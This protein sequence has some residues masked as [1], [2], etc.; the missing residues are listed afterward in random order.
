MKSSPRAFT[1]IELMLVIVIL[2]ISSAALLVNFRSASQK[3]L[4]EDQL[5]N[6][7]NVIEKARS[8]SLTNYLVNDFE[9]AE[10][11]LL[12]IADNSI[13][14]EA[15][16]DYG[17]TH[18]TLEEYDLPIGFETTA[19]DDEIFYFPPYGQ[20]CLTYSCTMAGFTKYSFTVSS[21][22]GSLTQTITITTHGG[23]AEFE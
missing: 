7:V 8:Y 4:F 18:E 1:L 11:Y 14:I 12:T 2:A 3:A 5:S 13:S 9:P 21:S 15:Y 17:G 6:I 19:A 10:Y 22:D 20:V 23:F 16:A